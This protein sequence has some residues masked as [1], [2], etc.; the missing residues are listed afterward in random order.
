VKFT[1]YQLATWQVPETT[2]AATTDDGANLKDAVEHRA[3]FW[4][5]LTLGAALAGA[6]LGVTGRRGGGV[7]A[8]VGLL[9]VFIL[10]IASEPLS[11][12]A[13]DVKFE[14]GFALTTLLYCL[15]AFWHAIVSI[16]RRSGSRALDSA[17]TRHDAA[18]VR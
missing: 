10:I 2:P 15:L 18:S 7:A 14:D 4:A 9:G 6:L 11:L 5:L 8:I 17:V 1:G 12:D 16:R 13:P 3:S